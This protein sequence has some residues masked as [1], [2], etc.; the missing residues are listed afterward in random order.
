MPSVTHKRVDVKEVVQE[1]SRSHG[2]AKNSTLSKEE[3]EKKK[4]EEAGK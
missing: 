2:V 3:F 4:L 1:K